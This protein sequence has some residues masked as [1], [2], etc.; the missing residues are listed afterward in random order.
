MTQEEQLKNALCGYDI[1]ICWDRYNFFK[2]NW[3]FVA[4]I[5]ECAFLS[6]SDLNGGDEEAKATFDHIKNNKRVVSYSYD[7]NPIIALKKA[8]AIFK[9]ELA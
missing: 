5:H 4:V 9:K 8:V 6:T 3:G 1:E 7:Q 2:S